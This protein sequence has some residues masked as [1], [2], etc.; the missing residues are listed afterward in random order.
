MNTLW[1]FM[2]WLEM[3]KKEKIVLDYMRK[4]AKEYWSELTKEYTKQFL[5]MNLSD[6]ELDELIEEQKASYEKSKYHYDNK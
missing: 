6:K 2:F 4:K 1:K 5:S 3:N